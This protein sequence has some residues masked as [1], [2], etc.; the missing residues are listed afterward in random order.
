LLPL[1]FTEFA[2]TMSRYVEELEKLTETMRERT[3][4]TNRLIDEHAY[5]LASSRHDPVGPPAREAQVPYV[6]FAPLKNAIAELTAS[7]RACDE[8]YAKVLVE[9]MQLTAAQRADINAL[10]RAS[11]QQLLSTRGLP[12]RPWYQHLIY[13]PGRE[14]GYAAKTLPG[15]REAIELRHFAEA[16]D[17][18]GV[19]ADALEA[20]REQIDRITTALR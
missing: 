14:T 7:A 1:H 15:V 9:P 20:Y 10:L 16:A 13:A 17:F 6:N 11:E 2:A 4:E 12:G 3:L 19:T 8:A 5:D 18:V